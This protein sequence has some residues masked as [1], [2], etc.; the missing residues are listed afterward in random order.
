MS[1]I[2]ERLFRDVAEGKPTT[3]EPIPREPD[4]G[5]KEF[6][7]P[8]GIDYRLTLTPLSSVAYIDADINR[9]RDARTGKTIS[10]ET[11]RE[12][13]NAWRQHFL[14]EIIENRMPS[15]DNVQRREVI[16][17]IESVR[18]SE[19]ADTEKDKVIRG[20]LGS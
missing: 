4:I 7:L 1:N 6:K 19:I 16:E 3:Y 14:N 15:L 13:V 10:G 5:M 20:L 12:K 8:L 2:R 18:A 17:R 9:Y 11:Y